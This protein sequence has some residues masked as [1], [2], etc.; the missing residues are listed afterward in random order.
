[1]HASE[2]IASLKEMLDQGTNGS[3]IPQTESDPIKAGMQRILQYYMSPDGRTTKIDIVMK[4]NPFQTDTM[5]NVE[6]I[7]AGLRASLDLSVIADPQ[8][9]ASGAT[10][11][12]NEL[13]DISYDDF[14]RTGTLVL[15]GIAIVLMLLLR[16]IIGPLYV[17]AALGFNYLITMGIVEFLYVKILGFDGLSWTASFFIFM[18]IVALGVDYSIFLMA[19][20]REELR[21][22][23]DRREA[24]TKAMTTTGGINFSAAAIMAGTFGA[25]GFSGVDTLIQI[26]VGTMIGL[27]LYATLFMSLVVP[28][29]TFLIG[30]RKKSCAYK[31]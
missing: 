26:G 2:G 27:M 11:K 21:L 29:L 20:Y 19:R 5:D 23:G 15:V 8:V 6:T 28:A 1:L 9:Y 24:I 31:S 25:L 14:V 13:R 12:Y 3:R 7:T 4:S 10:A 16:S 18:V 17:L 22:G 30:K